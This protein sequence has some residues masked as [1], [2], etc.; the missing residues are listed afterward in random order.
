MRHAESQTIFLTDSFQTAQENMDFDQNLLDLCQTSGHRYVRLYTWK[1]AGVTYSSKHTFP[2]ELKQGDHSERLTGGGIVFHQPG[3]V[4]ITLVTTL[5]DPLF[6]GKFKDK[7]YFFPQMFRQVLKDAGV[8]LEPVKVC[9]PQMHAYCAHYDSPY[10]LTYKGKKIL[11]LSVRKW[12]HHWM[13]QGV[14]HMDEEI[15]AKISGAKIVNQLQDYLK[16][17]MR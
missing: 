2:E 14:F 10:E 16:I 5:D 11:G 3:D 6:P 4:L 15:Q 9:K 1:N 13:V 8:E 17:K 7:L 12:K